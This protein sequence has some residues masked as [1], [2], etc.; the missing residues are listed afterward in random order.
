M[1]QSSEKQCS[2]ILSKQINSTIT[3]NLHHIAYHKWK[4]TESLLQRK[5]SDM[6]AMF[7]ILQH[8]LPQQHSYTTQSRSGIWRTCL[9]CSPQ[10]LL[11]SHRENPVCLSVTAV[12]HSFTFVCSQHLWPKITVNQGKKVAEKPHAYNSQVQ[13]TREDVNIMLGIMGWCWEFLLH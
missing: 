10:I 4:I 12:F 7:L 2:K 6:K 13:C 3:A 5:F 8:Q 9:V 1:P 11:L